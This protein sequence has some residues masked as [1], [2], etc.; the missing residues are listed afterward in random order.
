MKKQNLIT[1]LLVG[2]V[3]SIPALSFA[4]STREAENT[5]EKG[6]VTFNAGAGIGNVY[7]SNY[8]NTGFGTKAAVEKGLWRVG[9]GVI[10]LG[11]QTGGSFSSS[12]ALD[13]YKEKTFIIA[14]RAAWHHGWN[15]RNLDTYAGLSSG[16][17]FN[18]YSYNKNG[19]VKQ[20]EVVPVFGGF[21]GASYFI[22]PSFGF[23]IEAG[24]DITRI[25]GGIVF[26]LR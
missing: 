18:Q 23:N 6:T 4:Q 5:F 22:T 24:Y 3:T 2:I 20:D 16:A 9:P 17:G 25:Q 1:T 11:L 12:G 7:N 8:S 14:A 13:D 10:A 15:I 21:V 26:K 19:K